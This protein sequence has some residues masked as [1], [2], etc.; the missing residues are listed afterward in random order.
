MIFIGIHHHSITTNSISY[1][2][3]ICPFHFL[4]YFY[5]DRIKT[6]VVSD[7]RNLTCR[8]KLKSQ[9]HTLGDLNIV[10]Q[11]LQKMNDFWFITNQIWKPILYRHNYIHLTLIKKFELWYTK[12]EDK[13]IQL[14][15]IQVQIWDLQM[16]HRLCILRTI[17]KWDKILLQEV[18]V[19]TEH[20][21]E[22]MTE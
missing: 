4:F 17:I 15:Y 1:F 5:F 6:C 20:K 16:V 2:D 7:E 8:K 3:T 22:W 11:I 18:V 19:E 10:L 9:A 21:N 13:Y 14:K 12:M